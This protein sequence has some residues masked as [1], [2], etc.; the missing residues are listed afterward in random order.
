MLTEVIDF[1]H[2]KL[3]FV[4]IAASLFLML[5]VCFCSSN[6]GGTPTAGSIVTDGGKVT[7]D[8][9]VSFIR[10]YG[11]LNVCKKTLR[12]EIIIND[13]SKIKKLLGNAFPRWLDEYTD[14]ILKVP[15]DVYV[16]IGFDVNEIAFSIKEEGTSEFTA[17]KPTPIVDITGIYIRFDEELRKI[18]LLRWDISDEEFSS[19]WQDANVPALIKSQITKNRKDEFIDA[20]VSE[21]VSSILNSVRNRYRT[22]DFRFESAEKDPTFNEIPNPII[23][24]K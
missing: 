9:L 5:F 16:E 24:K 3:R 14:R 22:I 18:G 6:N 7:K 21:A 11:K 4:V 10:H 20:V 12:Q 19:A 15:Y 23:E 17:T 13:T 1:L 2:R 8:T